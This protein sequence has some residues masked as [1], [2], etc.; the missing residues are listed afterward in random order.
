[1]HSFSEGAHVTFFFWFS[2]TFMSDACCLLRG[3]LLLLRVCSNFSLFN[4]LVK[5]C[6]DLM[7]ILEF[8]FSTSGVVLMF[9]FQGFNVL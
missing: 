4:A 7:Q 3:T 5:S 2:K 1:M 9:C 8:A 6:C